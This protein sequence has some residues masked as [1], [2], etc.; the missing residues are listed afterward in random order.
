MNTVYV[1]ILMLVIILTLLYYYKRSDES[2][3]MK[4]RY[5]IAIDVPEYS[6]KNNDDPL[7]IYVNSSIKYDEEGLNKLKN[8]LS[9]KLNLLNKDSMRIIYKG[10]E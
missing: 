9:K 3:K 5:I 1:I 10:Y 2:G 8:D 6:N 4:H 7:L